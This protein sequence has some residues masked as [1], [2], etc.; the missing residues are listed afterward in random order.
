LFFYKGWIVK[1]RKIWELILAFFC[2]VF[3]QTN[4]GFAADVGKQERMQE[5]E[6]LKKYELE[7]QSGIS[8][9]KVAGIASAVVA[10]GLI[11]AFLYRVKC[12]DEDDNKQDEG[13]KKKS[14]VVK[15]EKRKRHKSEWT[16]CYAY[17]K[18]QRIEGK[19]NII[20]AFRKAKDDEEVDSYESMYLHVNHGRREGRFFWDDIYE[21]GHST[22]L[23]PKRNSEDDLFWEMS[24]FDKEKYS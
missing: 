15:D 8:V 22:D 4:V 2:L 6:L 5:L 9:Y 24:I 18:G 14:N 21:F 13:N 17:W 7:D 20:A 19:K 12:W 1:L 11:G 3:F 23:Y 16:E 10:V